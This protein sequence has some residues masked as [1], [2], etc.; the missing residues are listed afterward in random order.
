MSAKRL[1]AREVPAIITFLMVFVIQNTQNRDGA[2]IQA[3]LDRYYLRSVNPAG[4]RLDGTKQEFA[5]LTSAEG[6]APLVNW[7]VAGHDWD[8]MKQ[9]LR[10]LAV[11][12]ERGWKRITG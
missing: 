8:G 6:H 9:R 4:T 5:S 10:E 3:K 7:D 11:D 12:V 2:A 1:A